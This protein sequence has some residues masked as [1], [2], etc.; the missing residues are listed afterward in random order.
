MQSQNLIVDNAQCHL[1]TDALHLRQLAREARNKWDRGTYVRTCVMTAWTSLEVACQDA[2]ADNSI[3]YSF[4]KYLDEAV[5]KAGL[6]P[7]D[8]S[9]GAW[10]KARVLQ[11]LRKAY[12]HR[13]LALDN[14]FPEVRTA[15]EA[16]ETVRE[17]MSAIYL[18]AKLSPPAWI[19]Y[20][21]SHGWQTS[22][23][24]NG[25]FG[26]VVYGGASFDDPNTVRIF[27]VIDDEEHLTTVLPT[28]TD[29]SV[30]IESLKHSVKIPF[31]GIKAHDSGKLT[32]DVAVVVRGSN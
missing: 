1:W 8:W 2:L 4:K 5:Q 26:N 22:T 6:P 32:H 16:V 3:G 14:Y 13:Y 24:F 12:P 9:R 20:N 10:Q 15:D 28:G 11:E 7:L 29:P 27:F 21:K 18:H 31:N 30:Q 19:S 25:A 23:S 17:V